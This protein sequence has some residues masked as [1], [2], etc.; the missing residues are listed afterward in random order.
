[1]A[2]TTRCPLQARQLGIARGLHLLS[3]DLSGV[4]SNRQFGQEGLSTR[5]RRPFRAGIPSDESGSPEP[6]RG[7]DPDADGKEAIADLNSVLIGSEEPGKLVDTTP[8]SSENPPWRRFPL[9]EAS[10]K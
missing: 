2:G 7:R 10:G 8:G 1:M 4:F 6:S 9:R 3:V 5:L